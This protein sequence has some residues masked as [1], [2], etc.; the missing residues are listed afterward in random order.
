MHTNEKVFSTV[1]GSG[2]D[3][4]SCDVVLY[5]CCSMICHSQYTAVSIKIGHV[6]VII[7]V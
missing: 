1:V 6:H 2:G 7:V 3:G 4:G 5:C